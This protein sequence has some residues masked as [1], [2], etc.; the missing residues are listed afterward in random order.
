M[1]LMSRLRNAAATLAFS[2]PSAASSR[3][4]RWPLL[5]ARVVDER[6]SSLGTQ[7]VALSMVSTPLLLHCRFFEAHM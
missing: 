1:D 7:V 2:F 5:A 6:Q 4:W 3:L